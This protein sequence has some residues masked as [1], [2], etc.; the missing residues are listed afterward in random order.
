MDREIVRVQN[1][2]RGE[3][4]VEDCFIRP[5]DAFTCGF[6]SGVER[7]VLMTSFS[8]RDDI[9]YPEVK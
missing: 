2:P 7:H 4:F 8:K 5:L 1:D 6:E 3:M 9:G